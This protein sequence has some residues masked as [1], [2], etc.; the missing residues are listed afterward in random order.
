MN[1][2]LF[3]VGTDA[4]EPDDL[5]ARLARQLFTL[6]DDLPAVFDGEWSPDAQA[7][8]TTDRDRPLSLGGGIDTVFELVQHET[9]Q[10]V[11]VAS[12]HLIGL[13][14]LIDA[15]ASALAPITLSRTAYETSLRAV[16]LI[17]VRDDWQRRTQRALSRRLA[18]WHVD[19]RQL[20]RSGGTGAFDF[21]RLTIDEQIQRVLAFADAEAWPVGKPRNEAP[22]VGESETMRQLAERLFV[23]SDHGDF[24]WRDTSTISH[25]DLS[26][27][28][29]DWLDMFDSSLHQS[30]P[31]WW[32]AQQTVPAVAAPVALLGSFQEYAGHDVDAF[33]RALAC[34]HLWQV[35]GGLA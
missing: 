6:A 16:S 21:D 24:L 18:R 33:S 9:R 29:A 26:A 23:G 10:L 35:A 22:F 27:D 17:D 31:V 32:L 8:G 3:G 1:E 11:R 20:D 34:R 19:R 30:A 28:I 4:R 25:G 14:T 5:R 12:D 15:R 7:L 13:A 2:I